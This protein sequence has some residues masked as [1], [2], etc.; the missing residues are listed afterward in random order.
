[1]SFFFIEF[2]CLFEMMACF[3]FFTKTRTSIYV[4]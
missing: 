4:L 3:S 1:M 2:A